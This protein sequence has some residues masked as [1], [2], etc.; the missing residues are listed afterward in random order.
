MLHEMFK[1]VLNLFILQLFD[2]K[3]SMENYRS[4]DFEQIL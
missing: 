1:I 4:V 2:F 3:L